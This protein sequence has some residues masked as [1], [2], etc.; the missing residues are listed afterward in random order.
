[1]H[2]RNTDDMYL[3]NLYQD[4]NTMDK[5][6]LIHYNKTHLDIEHILFHSNM[7]VDYNIDRY[8]QHTKDLLLNHKNH[9]M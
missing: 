8:P 2:N 3:L 4:K 5:Y 9:P 7:S 6:N 1:M